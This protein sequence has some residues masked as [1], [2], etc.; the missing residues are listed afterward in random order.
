[1]GDLR[2]GSAQF[3]ISGFVTEGKKKNKVQTEIHLNLESPSLPSTT[4]L[5]APTHDPPA[6]VWSTILTC[7]D[8]VGASLGLPG[9]EHEHR[10]V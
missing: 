2:L 1:M 5:A 3:T 9:N 10:T 8:A 4:L 7:L 6:G